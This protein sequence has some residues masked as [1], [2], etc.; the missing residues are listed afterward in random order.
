[1]NF[2][3]MLMSLFLVVFNLTLPLMAGIYIVGELG[4]NGSV[5]I[6]AVSLYCLGNVITLPLGREGTFSLGDQQLYCICF[7]IMAFASLGCA[8]S[9]DY[10]VFLLFRF[11]E[12]LAGGPLYLILTRKLI[13]LY[14]PKSPDFP[15]LPILLTFFACTPVIGASW[16]GWIAYVYH[17][18]F[19]FYSNTLVLFSLMF[20]IGYL[21]IPAT[22]SRPGRFPEPLTFFFYAAGFFCL[23]VAL[24]TGQELD[25][26][27]ST[28]FSTLFVIGMVSFIAFLV[29]NTI[30]HQTVIN[31]SL[32]KNVYFCLWTLN[33]VF[34]FSAYFG[35]VILFS[36]WLKL[37]VNY[38]P[39][40]IA[41]LLLGMAIGA[42]IPIY[43][44]VRR[45]DPRWPLLVALFILTASSYYTST[46]N[47][48]INFG[49]LMISRLAA[50]V[51][52]ALFLP[53]LFRLTVN[54]HPEHSED[55]ITL[56]HVIRIFACGVGASLY[57]ILW[58]RRQVFYHERF[59]EY[60]TS[61]TLTGNEF[62]Y[63]ILP[64]NLSGSDKIVKLNEIL[65]QQ[66]TAFA[67]DDCFILMTWILAGLILM[68]VLTFFHRKEIAFK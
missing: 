23:G 50:G 8:W 61:F 55:S 14:A 35:M 13:P 21:Q 56:F 41:V 11:V 18:R 9:G 28:V 31:L 20:Y 47:E 65:A 43:L 15:L 68:I 58:Q 39:N 1:M 40:W 7:A 60:L 5:V 16:G 42:F 51:G 48:E 37:Y 26:F 10:F 34:I 29:L 67:L 24:T 63:R 30:H 57:A 2:I 59:G 12:G 19:L 25:W 32:F 54:V 4:G 44:S 53:P 3:I 66:S 46:F 52:L 62:A 6:Y 33:V 22:G 38:T 64:E 17:W 27:R 45:F 49:R 36:L